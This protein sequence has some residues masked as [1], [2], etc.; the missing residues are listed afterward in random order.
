M[1]F[2]LDLAKSQSSDNPVYYIQYAHARICSTFRKLTEKQLSHDPQ[3]G[4]ENLSLLTE[5]HETRIIST[6]S[7]YP[8]IVEK[9]ALN[10]E[11]HQ[12][13][14]YLR[15][16]ANELHTYYNAH[17]FIVDDETLRNARLN[18]I[19]ATRHVLHNG[20]KLLGVSAPESM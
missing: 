11:P 15:E 7:K 17:K 10:E 5:S 13:A 19:N 2:D 8:E 14:H 6:L 20:L 12:L 4:S 9:S 16:L 1:D 18:L 3:Q